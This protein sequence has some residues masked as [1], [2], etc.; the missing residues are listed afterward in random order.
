MAEPDGSPTLGRQGS[1]RATTAARVV[2]W[3]AAS[4]PF[5]VAALD[6]IRRGWAPV[7]DDAV[8]TMRSFQVIG[9]HSP[10]VGQ[11]SQASTPGHP[12]FDLGPLM[13]WVLAVPIHLDPAKGALWG[14]ALLCAAASILAVEAGWAVAGRA[15]AVVT[16]AAVLAAV[17]GVRSWPLDPVWNPHFGLSFYVATA[18]GAWAVA[19][20]RRW[21]LPVVAFTASLA[22]EA[23]VMYA[24]S[25]FILVA[26]AVAVGVGGAQRGTRREWGLPVLAAAVVILACWIAPLVQQIAG[27]PGN[28]SALW[29]WDIGRQKLGLAFGLRA[30]SA[31]GWWHPLWWSASSSFD[32]FGIYGRIAHAPLWAGPVLLAGTAVIGAAAWRLGNRRLGTLAAVT[33]AAMVGLVATYG[34]LASTGAL[35]LSYLDV[36]A[37]PAGILIWICWT[38]ALTE[39]A[40]ALL[41]RGRAV[42]RVRAPGTRSVELLLAA[43]VAVLVVL[44]SAIS[45]EVVGGARRDSSVAL[46]WSST[47]QVDAINRDFLAL[48][49]PHGPVAVDVSV[50]GSSL[51]SYG[52]TYGL[53]WQLVVD[54][55]S[56]ELPGFFTVPVGPEI[57]IRQGVEMVQVLETPEGPKLELTR[58]G[59]SSG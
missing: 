25:T 29:S 55:Y 44:A 18:A 11:F 5:V 12:I 15:G 1:W 2:A 20:G 58:T 19:A 30:L 23:H 28:L 51:L 9:S 53:M 42:G 21:W 33:L 39:A 34:G 6:A 59:S 57:G 14:A 49:L 3:L 36:M 27:H 17:A 45:V 37:W 52:D 8:I 54:G 22:A 56:P 10:L 13:Y 32:F 38:W 41:A 40:V 26:L 46:L 7:G 35:E 4:T 48:R 16:S 43:G 31:T 47:R 24:I 50:P